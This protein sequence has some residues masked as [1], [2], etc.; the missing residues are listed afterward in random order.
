MQSN[1]LN[2]DI[3]IIGGGIAGCIAGIALS[4][5]YRV[6]IV[7]KSE[8]PHARIGECL[9]PPAR[10]ILQQLGLQE[11][12]ESS[13]EHLV[14]L[15]M[16]SY[17]GSEQV[18]IVDHLSN[19]DGNGWYLN[20]K[21]FEQFLRQS[22]IDRGVQWICPAQLEAIVFQDNQWELDVRGPLT[23]H[24]INAS[25]VIDA[26]GRQSHFARK[27]G[28][29]REAIDKL[30]SC[31]GTVPYQGKRQ[32]GTIATSPSGWWYASPLPQQRMLLAY[33]TDA[34]LISKD[35]GKNRTQFL[36]Q[37]KGCPQLTSFISGQETA[38]DFQGIVAANS[39]RLEAV[40]G[41]Q[42]AAIGDAAISFDPLSAQGMYNAM[43]SAMQLVDLLEKHQPIETTSNAS[44]FSE[45]YTQQINAIWSHYL[46]HRR[47]FYG[48]EQRWK[49]A[50]FWQRRLESA[51]AFL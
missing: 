45:V 33:H 46:K 43:A 34:D 49:E 8:T 14:N 48:Q 50:A 35:F 5:R 21:S 24:Q 37:M 38:L 27:I 51:S 18:H 9:A 47:V 4:D 10:R 2:T 26:S 25:F 40:S 19:P 44:S 31:W 30:V 13:H 36:E 17:W 1:P 16:Q 3:A 15:G 11:A 12:L 22:A 7:E 23:A 28:V 41:N 42:W 32:L 20:R 29:Q 39:T 6:T